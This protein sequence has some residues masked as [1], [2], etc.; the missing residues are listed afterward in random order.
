MLLPQWGAEADSQ[1]LS[2]PTRSC[3]NSICHSICQFISPTASHCSGRAHARFGPTK[4]VVVS[5]SLGPWFFFSWFSFRV[6]RNCWTPEARILHNICVQTVTNQS[7]RRTGIY[8]LITSP[9]RTLWMKEILQ[10]LPTLG[11][12]SLTGAVSVG[13][14]GHRHVSH[15]FT[16]ISTSI[17]R[18]FRSH[19]WQ[20]DSPWESAAELLVVCSRW[21]SWT[22]WNV[23]LKYCK[24]ISCLVVMEE[25]LSA[26]FFFFFLGSPPPFSVVFLVLHLCQM[27]AGE[28]RVTTGYLQFS[29]AKRAKG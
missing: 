25:D 7:W 21:N 8:F 19:C 22:G 5:F 18:R 1:G 28:S 10:S 26:A 20:W 4:T 16:Q 11:E 13:Q 14:P 17:T 6:L 3:R 27:K 9:S 12:R 2:E 29:P 23:A 15:Q 24:P